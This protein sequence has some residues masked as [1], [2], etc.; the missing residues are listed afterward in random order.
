MKEDRLSRVAA[1]CA[2]A[3]VSLLAG[4]FA[5]HR[6]FDFDV[7]WHVKTGG[8]ILEAGR[9][10]WTDP[11]GGI[12]AGE[13]W[14]DVA[15]GAQVAAALIARVLGLTGLQLLM[16]ALVMGTLL[17]FAWRAP[18]TPL[19]LV[20]ALLF[21]ILCGQRFLVRPDLLAFPLTL[22]AVELIERI[23][24]G[25]RPALAG[26]A[27]LSALWVN[28]HGSFILVPILIVA[29]AVGSVRSPAPAAVLRSYGAALGIFAL[30][31]LINPYTFRIYRLFTPYFRSLLASVGLLP[32][33]EYLGVAEWTP[34]WRAAAFDPIFPTLA[35]LLFLLV[36]IVSFLRAAGTAPLSRVLCAAS[37]AVLGLGAVR[38]LLPFGAASLAVI[39]WNERDRLRRDQGGAGMRGRSAGGRRAAVIGAA[40]GVLVVAGFFGRAVLTDGYYVGRNLPIVTGVGVDPDLA[41]EGAVGWLAGHEAPGRLFNNYN[42]GAYL[43]YRLHPRVRPYIDAR[44]DTSRR[45]QEVERLLGVEDA[46]DAWVRREG[47]GTIVLLH[48]SPE[49]LVLLPHLSR[50]PAWVMAFRDEN[51]TVHV[52]APMEARAR[53]RP[54][55]LPPAVEPAAEA[56]N[57]RLGRFKRAS[58]PAAE[59]T[60]AFVSRILG[61]LEGEREAY[62]RALARSPRNPAALGYFAGQ[63]GP[64]VP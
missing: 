57:A 64:P 43:L 55:P 11:F 19:V 29:A 54:I 6:I 49:S 47:I 1:W 32:S 14:L 56:I 25:S 61:D 62:R 50:D 58:L 63:G 53:A 21:V 12:T 38:N 42:S 15:W 46:F 4:L 7:F 18:G 17:L 41:P 28:L 16:A 51:S 8:W 39:A 30:G 5:L 26:V 33:A 45:Y 52:R 40:A 60:D 27:L 10:P 2:F 35:F 24:R 44:F 22:L 59:L 23:R 9:V 31:S 36:L 34:T 20:S 13:P 3:A 48:P 37:L